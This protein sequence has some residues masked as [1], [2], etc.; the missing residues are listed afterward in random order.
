MEMS[1]EIKCMKNVQKGKSLQRE[2]SC[3]FESQGTFKNVFQEKESHPRRLF[4]LYSK[5][6]T[7]LIH[8]A[9]SA[10]RIKGQI[11]QVMARV[12]TVT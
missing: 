10:I 6:W 5:L 3:P 11:N 9:F 8:K 2:K 12:K 1:E 4:K 7:K